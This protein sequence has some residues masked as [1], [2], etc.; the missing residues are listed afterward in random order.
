MSKDVLFDTTEFRFNRKRTRQVFWI[1][2]S[3][4]VPKFGN[5]R[6]NLVEFL[7]QIGHFLFVTQCT[8]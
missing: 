7:V 4:K 2:E 1:L 3:A 6:E 5:F 8:N